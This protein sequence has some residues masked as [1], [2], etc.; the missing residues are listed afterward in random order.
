MHILEIIPQQPMFVGC[1][2]ATKLGMGSIWLPDTASPAHPQYVWCSQFPPDI[3]A[4]LL[5]D[6]NPWG[7]ITNSDLELAGTI[8]QGAPL[9]AHED[10]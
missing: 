5:S 4:W 9:V 6:R 10:M 2:D 8:R 7:T 1:C 3:Q